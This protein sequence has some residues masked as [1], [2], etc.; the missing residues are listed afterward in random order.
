MLIQR[1]ARRMMRL[2]SSTAQT[3]CKHTHSGQDMLNK[4]DSKLALGKKT[5]VTDWQ[6]RPFRVEFCS[7]EVKV[8][9]RFSVSCLTLYGDLFASTINYFGF[10]VCAL[11]K[12]FLNL[13][14]KVTTKPVALILFER[15]IAFLKRRITYN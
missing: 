9:K 14:S 8:E 5:A 1:V 2:K 15:K 3:F 11:S 4:F 12:A 13:Q 7:R 6:C 10:C